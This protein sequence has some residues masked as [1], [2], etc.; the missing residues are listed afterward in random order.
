MR[1]PSCIFN[2]V[3][4]RNKGQG[5]YCYSSDLVLIH[6]TSL[7]AKLERLKA[8]WVREGDAC[9]LSVKT[10]KDELVLILQEVRKTLVSE[11]STK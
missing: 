3:L 1:T 11:E 5:S 8:E 2:F 4:R 10:M 7:I 9:L 6:N